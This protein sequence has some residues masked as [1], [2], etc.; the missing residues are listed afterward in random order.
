MDKSFTKRLV[1]LCLLILVVFAS[2]KQASADQYAFLVGVRDYSLNN[3]LTPLSYSENDVEDLATTLQQAGVPTGNITLM[4][5]T[6]AAKQ[7]RYTPTSRQIRKEL[8]MVLSELT[9]QDSII[10]GF[11]GHGLQFKGDPVNY[12]CPADASLEDK[13]TLIS[14]SSIYEDLHACKA[15]AKFLLV[16]ACRNDP[17]SNIRKAPRR[18]TIED[19]KSRRPPVPSGGTVALFSCSASQFSFEHKELENGVFFYFVNEAFS[20]KAD[21]DRDGTIDHLEL[22]SYTIK[23]VQQWTR[24]HLGEPQT[25]ERIGS[26]RGVMNLLV[27][28]ANRTPTQSHRDNVARKEL[29]TPDAVVKVPPRTDAMKNAPPFA[30]LSSTE[31]IDL[32]KLDFKSET[33]DMFSDKTQSS[34]GDTNLDLR[35]LNRSEKLERIATNY[36][37]N[38]YS[39]LSGSGL[40]RQGPLI[41]LASDDE[42]LFGFEADYIDATIQ[43]TSVDPKGPAA[44]SGLKPGDRI[45]FKPPGNTTTPSSL[46]NGVSRFQS[47]NHFQEKFRFKKK[48]DVLKLVIRRDNMN[49]DFWLLFTVDK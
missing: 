12:F 49:H 31:M 9:E 48:D 22:E 17:L 28:S 16:D 7:A 41:L 44:G 46:Y 26:A 15:G 43:V 8:S 20:G 13:S 18:I 1:S 36:A 42:G 4:T 37:L 25:P 19:V 39:V 11:S 6:A 3:E 21:Q 14:L 27:M 45:Y 29:D 34:S 47:L 32:S 2:R 23:R 10:I 24:I 38:E 30:D 40:R 33:P 5:Q 35:D